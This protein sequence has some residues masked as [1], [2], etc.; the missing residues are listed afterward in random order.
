M[1]RSSSHSLQFSNPGKRQEIFNFLD[2]Y[3]RLADVILTGLWDNGLVEFDIDFSIKE[4]KLSLP[5]MLPND[6]LKRFDSWFTARMKQCVGKQVCSMIRAAVKKRQKQLWMLRKLQQE[7]KDTKYLQRKIDIQPLVKPKTAKIRAELDPRFVD[8]QKGNFFD[9]FVRIKQIGKGIS[10]N[11]PVKQTKV[12]R[13]WSRQGLQKQSVRLSEDQIV[14]FFEVQQ[15]KPTGTKTVGADQGMLT[16]LSLS[17]QQVTKKCPHGHDLVS[18]QEKLA[19]RQKGS[20]GFKKAQEHRTNYINW[21]LNQ[22]NFKEIKG[23]RLEKVYRIRSKKSSSRIMT[24]WTYTEI[25]KKLK[26]LSETEGFR[27][28]EVP[29]EFRSQR[30]SQCGKVRKA[31]RRKKTFICD[32]CGFTADADLNAAFNLELDLFE[33]PYWVRLEKINRKGFYWMPDGLFDSAWE[34]IVPTAKEA[35]QT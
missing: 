12:S 34:P 13:K 28:K 10:F 6:S 17:D 7:G 23:V 2:E 26:L 11:I 30:C 33:I 22:L 18:I 21:S 8:F 35:L 3:R 16:C 31:N 27:F 32:A 19:R 29:N 15:T 25:K 4:N 5:S 14:I 24:H 1:I 20:K 9:F